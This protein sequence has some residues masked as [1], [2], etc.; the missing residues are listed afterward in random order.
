MCSCLRICG[1][2]KLSSMH[3]FNRAV[4]Y[5][6]A[7]EP[8]NSDWMLCAVHCTMYILFERQHS[9]Y[10]IQITCCCFECGRFVDLSF[11]ENGYQRRPFIWYGW[12]F[13]VG[14][15]LWNKRTWYHGILISPHICSMLALIKFDDIAVIGQYVTNCGSN[16]PQ[17]TDIPK[18]FRNVFFLFQTVRITQAISWNYLLYTLFMNHDSKDHAYVFF[19]PKH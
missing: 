1:R 5:S 6:N 15:F 12:R 7:R 2:K 9:N 19:L 16:C 8:H 14:A 11:T 3:K 4:T 18:M 10:N 13:F 17:K